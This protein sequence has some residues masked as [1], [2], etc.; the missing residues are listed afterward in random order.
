MKHVTVYTQPHCNYSASL[1]HS[2]NSD[3]VNK[4]IEIREKCISDP[5]HLAEALTYRALR[6]PLT[7]VDGEVFSG[8]ELT[9]A[10]RALKAAREG[11]E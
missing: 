4:D 7:V 2:L 8:Y 10:R 6:I 5:I 11:G 1:I 3:N 9:T